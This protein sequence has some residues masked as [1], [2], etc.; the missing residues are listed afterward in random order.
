MTHA[1][2]ESPRVPDKTPILTIMHFPRLSMILLLLTSC[3]ALLMTGLMIIIPVFPQR[4]QALGLGAATLAWMEMAFGPAHYGAI[5]GIYVLALAV[6]PLLIS[7][8]LDGSI[9]LLLIALEC[10]LYTGLNVGMLFFIQYP[11][12]IL[13]AILAGIG[14]A[15][16]LPGLGVIYLC[17]TNEQHRSQV[18]GLRQTALALG[19]LLG[20]LLQ[21]LMIPWMAPR[22]SFAIGV[23]IPIGVSILVLTVLLSRSQHKQREAVK[24]AETHE[25]VQEC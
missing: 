3:V 8:F 2:Q 12:L 13:A 15:F 1:L 22:T 9:K 10:L 4:L 6:F 20:P 23:I 14:Q 18:M 5:L 25:Q 16:W 17:A 21:A 19:I 11:F 7:R 24:T